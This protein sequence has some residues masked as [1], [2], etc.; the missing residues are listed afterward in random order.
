MLQL[1]SNLL[2][3]PGIGPSTAIKLNSKFI[4]TIADLLFFFPIRYKDFSQISTIA[5]LQA[6]EEV[7]IQGRV[8]SCISMRTRK[9]NLTMQKI[10]IADDTKTITALFFNQPYICATFLR[11]SD[12]YFSGTVDTFG[13]FL[14]FKVAEYASLQ[15]TNSIHTATL[16]PYYRTIEK[17]SVRYIR[18][19]VQKILQLLPIT[20]FIETLPKWV[21][22]KN[23]LLPLYDTIKTLHH[24]ESKNILARSRHRLIYEELFQLLLTNVRIS[25]KRQ[26]F[27]S[28]SLS[29]VKYRDI[30]EKSLP[31]TLTKD[32]SN[33]IDTIEQDMSKQVPM[34]RLVI[35]DVGCG[36]TVVAACCIF[37]T[38]KH[39]FK[40]IFLVPTSLLS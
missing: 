30:F 19:L 33:V 2:E 39:G 15:D 7:S 17:M 27:S 1:N 35:G 22:Q 28:H 23:K 18:T 24:P 36:K 25:K 6:G 9:R 10:V 12:F 26:N 3:I 11:G 29:L 8:Q 20:T 37:A 5:S 13:T 38:A 31:F 21:V 40:T 16:V 14:V 32:Q 34:N 4:E